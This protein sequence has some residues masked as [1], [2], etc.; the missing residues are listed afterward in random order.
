L[1]LGAQS[2]LTTPTDQS[3]PNYELGPSSSYCYLTRPSL[4]DDSRCQMLWYVRFVDQTYTHLVSLDVWRSSRTSAYSFAVLQSSNAMIM[5]VTSTTRRLYLRTLMVP[6]GEDIPRLHRGLAFCDQH[7]SFGVSPP[8][9]RAGLC[10]PSHLLMTSTDY[11]HEYMPRLSNAI[12][13][14]FAKPTKVHSIGPFIARPESIR[15]TGRIRH[16]T[17]G[18]NNQVLPNLSTVR[19]PSL[20]SG[21]RT[22]PG[23]MPLSGSSSIVPSLT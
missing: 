4:S 14:P 5:P 1:V 21:M 9:A 20:R 8:V 18:R 15:Q 10:I 16:Q 6:V 17:S 13:G 22:F 19:L 12:N 3:V 11:P 23:M 2:N 7:V